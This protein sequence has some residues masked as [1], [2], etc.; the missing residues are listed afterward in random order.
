MYVKWYTVLPLKINKFQR[1]RTPCKIPLHST[2]P[3]CTA[4]KRQHSQI[5]L[6]NDQSC[7]H[8]KTCMLLKAIKREAVCTGVWTG[9]LSKHY[10]LEETG[11]APGRI[12]NTENG[13]LSA[14]L[15]NPH[16]R[17][18]DAWHLL[19][20]LGLM[21]NLWTVPVG[22]LL[23]FLFIWLRLHRF[24]MTWNQSTFAKKSSS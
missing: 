11:I 13:R 10:V 3:T 7:S 8:F 15:L 22:K 21:E 1:Y 19:I 18:M 12:S 24:A 17:L 4:V 6:N 2:K 16:C 9:C 23:W 14:A 20:R 5:C